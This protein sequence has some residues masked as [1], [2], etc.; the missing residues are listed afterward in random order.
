MYKITPSKYF[1]ILNC[2]S[3]ILAILLFSDS[4]ANDLPEKCGTFPID[5]SKS[6]YHISEISEFRTS[7]SG[8]FQVQYYTSGVDASTSE[9]VDSTLA[10][11]DHVYNVQINEL[12]YDPPPLADG[13][14]HVELI[15]LEPYNVY[16]YTQPINN[17]G[18]N[19]SSY[20]VLDNNYSYSTY[21]TSGLNGLRV[22]IAHEFFH[23]VQF[24]YRHSFGHGYLL[25]MEA[26]W[27]EDLVYDNIN[28][29]RNYLSKFFETPYYSI[30]NEEG[31]REYGACVF[32]KTITEGF[33]IDIIRESWELYEEYSGDPFEHL[34]QAM[35]NNN[36]SKSELA[37]KYISWMTYT[38]ERSIAGYGF[39]DAYFFPELE[40]SDGNI[41]DL[42][43]EA[44]LGEWGLMFGRLTGGIQGRPNLTMNS[45]YEATAISTVINQNIVESLYSNEIGTLNGSY[46]TVGAVSL[47]SEQQSV[48]LKATPERSGSPG[49]ITIYNP[50]PNPASTV[51]NIRILLDKPGDIT[52]DIYNLLGQ[53]IFSDFI[54]SSLSRETQYIWPCVDVNGRQIASGMYILQAVSGNTEKFEKIVIVRDKAAN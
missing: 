53:T 1:I 9:F 14:Y 54:P 25:E 33:D 44:E 21:P 16:G 52:I 41:A 6:S 37:S 17:E 35:E 50:Y 28:D 30:R 31:T 42:E 45:D 8:I 38:G 10:I 23:A 3:I 20:I 27:M 22:T 47:Y 34:I 18:V 39:D 43:W 29:Y 46:G 2:I 51:S 48:A 13:Y 36:V 26:V 40:L 32:I 49:N 15:D 4:Y 19:L 7:E 11:L 5:I 12:G 24:G